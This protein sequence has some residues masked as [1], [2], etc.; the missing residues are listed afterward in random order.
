MRKYFFPFVAVCAIIFFSCEQ[1][2]VYDKYKSFPDGW[3]KDSLATFKISEIDSSRTYNVFINVRN[4][5]NYRYSNLFLISEINFPNGK[6][7]TDTLEYE[8][9][10]PNGEWLGTGFGEVKESRLWLKQN[11][12]FS[13]HGEYKVTLQQAMRKNGETDGIDVL[14]GIT[15]IG[16]RIEKTNLENT[17]Q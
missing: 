9:A 4:N 15:D 12:R 16:I 1:E 8:M 11:V 17:A 14:E 6:V 3:A 2:R 5:N 10:A 7:L 13:E